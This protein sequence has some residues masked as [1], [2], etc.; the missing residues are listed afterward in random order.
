MNKSMFELGRSGV[1]IFG[2]QLVTPLISELNMAKKTSSRSVNMLFIGNSFTQRNSL[3]TL[4]AEMAAQRDVSINHEL[5]SAGGASLRTHWNAAR[6][7]ATI[8]S[9]G[10]DY[11]VLQVQS[12]LP[13]KTPSECPR[14]FVCSTR[15]FNRRAPRLCCT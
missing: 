14:M 7:A 15:R 10:F 12:T 2:A 9:G 13:L 5:I 8:A 4:V 11:V 3:P 6:A 1:I